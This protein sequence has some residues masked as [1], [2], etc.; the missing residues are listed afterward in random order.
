MSLDL[1]PEHADLVRKILAGRLPAGVSARVFGSRAKG[2][3]KP[4]SDLDLALKGDENLSFALLVDVMEAFSESE[5]PFKVDVLDWRAVAPGFQ[6]VIDR[7]GV[8]FWNGGR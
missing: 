8:D 6:E 5:L 7:D 1:K 4:Y 2:K 3:A